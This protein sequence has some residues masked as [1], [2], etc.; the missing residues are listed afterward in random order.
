MSLDNEAD[1]ERY[2]AMKAARRG[3]SSTYLVIA[4]IGA[5]DENAAANR[6]ASTSPGKWPCREMIA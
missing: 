4:K 6:R 1:T 5:N 2:H 3:L